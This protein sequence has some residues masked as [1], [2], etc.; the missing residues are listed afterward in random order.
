[1]TAPEWSVPYRPRGSTFGRAEREALDRVLAGEATLSCGGE[2][3]AFERDFAAA[4]GAEH[5]L[6]LTN[7]TVALEFATRL[8]DLRPGDEVLAVSQTYHA[9]VQ[10]LLDLDVDV[11]FCEID[12]R[13]LNVDCAR[14]DVGPRTRAIYV[15]HHGGRCIDLDALERVA[16]RHDLRIVEDCA[17]ALPSTHAGRHAG[18]LDLGCFSFQSYKNISTLGEGGMLTTR[19][20]D[21]AELVRLGRAI[22][23]LA[24]YAPRDEATL[25]GGRTGD[26]R[27]F[28]HHRRSF[29][30]DCRRIRWAGTNSTLAE[31]ACAVGRAQLTRLDALTER[32]RSVAARY[33]EAL[34]R[35]DDVALLAPPAPGDR[36]AHHLYSFRLLRPEGERDRLLSALVDAGVEVQQRYFPVHLMPE[37]RLRSPGSELPVTERVWFEEQVQLPIYPQLTD[38]QVE[39]VI[40]A[41]GRA[42]DAPAARLRPAA[43]G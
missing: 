15:V 23:P 7:C 19:R 24:E 39:H 25:G 1:V 28:W 18:T 13:T 33:D 12:A 32:R 21:E 34:S 5:A 16:R 20:A 37:W 42:L 26:P 35:F 30:R 9:T 14:L 38:A 11:R 43:A 3:D 36:H 29:E 27:V 40:R 2:R 31:P 41:V 17:H 4:V 10:P 22:E 6:A 8:I